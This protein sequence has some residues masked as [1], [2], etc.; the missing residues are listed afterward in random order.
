MRVNAE[1]EQQILEQYDL[2]T[3]PWAV[4]RRDR[5][6]LERVGR[7]VVRLA[8]A[9][10][11]LDRKYQLGVHPVINK[12]TLDT[13]K[14]TR[15]RG[16]TRTQLELMPERTGD[17]LRLL[18]TRTNLSSE[19]FSIDFDSTH[20]VLYHT[21]D[22]GYIPD[23]DAIRRTPSDIAWDA[24]TQPHVLHHFVQLTEGVAAITRGM[25]Q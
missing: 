25:K 13:V 18:A 11:S 20:C 21:W 9:K 7:A 3:P 6:H 5:G 14:I 10:E 12:K 15:G 4:S 16:L 22:N 1:R 8:D 19:Q 23:W 17:G 2:L 24:K